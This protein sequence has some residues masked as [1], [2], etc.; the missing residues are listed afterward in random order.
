MIGLPSIFQGNI[1]IE[2]LEAELRACTFTQP[3]V[4]DRG[5]ARLSDMTK[6]AAE[7]VLRSACRFL[8][9]VA[10]QAAVA[11]ALKLLSCVSAAA[12][13]AVAAQQSESSSASTAGGVSD[14]YGECKKRKNA[15]YGHKNVKLENVKYVNVKCQNVKYGHGTAI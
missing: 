9:P 15:K 10:H 6:E 7:G 2:Q 8:R 5:F 3:S 12:N 4:R 1:G 13:A 11:L 14:G